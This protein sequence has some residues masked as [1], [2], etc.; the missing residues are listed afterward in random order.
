MSNR[1]VIPT[2]NSE[3]TDSRS[4]FVYCI[5]EPHGYFKIGQAINV[6]SRLS[7]LQSAT[8]FELVVEG[9]IRVDDRCA[10]ERFIHGLLAQYHHRNEWYKLPNKSAWHDACAAYRKHLV[11]ESRPKPIPAPTYDNYSDDIR[12]QLA[13]LPT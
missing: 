6:Y 13:K 3:N 2:R 9:M 7:T 4:G 12:R 8:P 5:R 10:A 11:E 1:L